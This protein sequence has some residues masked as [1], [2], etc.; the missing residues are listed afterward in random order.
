M[1]DSSVESENGS[2]PA[3][4][5]PGSLLAEEQHPDWQCPTCLRHGLFVRAYYVSPTE[6][7]RE[8][9]ECPCCDYRAEAG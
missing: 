8:V 2:P 6:A 3:W 4:Y 7:P 1:P 9:V 5:T